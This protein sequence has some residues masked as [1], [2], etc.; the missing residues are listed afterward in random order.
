MSKT[1]ENNF[2]D[3]Q[4]DVSDIVT[5]INAAVE[6]L[7]NAE[8]CETPEDFDANVDEALEGLKAAISEI[9]GLRR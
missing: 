9:K 4:A 5:T 6:A 7:D 3:R 2:D 8:S 1:T